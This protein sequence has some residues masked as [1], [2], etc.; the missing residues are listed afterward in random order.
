MMLPMLFASLTHARALLSRRS[1][2]HFLR[3]L[4]GRSRAVPA[5]FERRWR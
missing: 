3:A 2:S 4:L 5:P 1:R